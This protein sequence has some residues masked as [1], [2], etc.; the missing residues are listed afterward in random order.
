MADNQ[1]I[2]AGGAFFEQLLEIFK[3]GF[4]SEGLGVQDLGLVAHLG[5]YERGGLE[6]ALKRAGDDEIELDVQCIQYMGELEAVLLS[7]FVEGTFLVEGWI[8][9]AKTGAGVT[10]DEDIHNLL[11]F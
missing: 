11:T 6:A 10:K 4:R 8:C 2:F 7:F 5:A 1:K 9:A 3:G